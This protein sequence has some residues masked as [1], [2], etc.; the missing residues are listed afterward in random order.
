MYLHNFLFK[1]AIQILIPLCQ[2]L[3]RF[4]VKPGADQSDSRFDYFKS[5]VNRNFVAFK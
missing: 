5:Q 3:H 2:E 4:D 1:N